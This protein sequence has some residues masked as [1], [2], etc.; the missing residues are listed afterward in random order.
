MDIC[1]KVGKSELT[2][3]IALYL[4]YEDNESFAE[5]YGDKGIIG[6]SQKD[7]SKKICSTLEAM[8]KDGKFVGSMAPYGYLIDSDD[9]HHLVVDE[10]VRDGI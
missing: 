6:L 1:K 5:V 10:E 2:A 9:R 4:L 8:M 7:I 3:A